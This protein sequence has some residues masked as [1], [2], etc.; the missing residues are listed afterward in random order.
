MDDLNSCRCSYINDISNVFFFPFLNFQGNM[1]GISLVWF[2][3]IK[4]SIIS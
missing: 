4:T 1:K 2:Q 3:S